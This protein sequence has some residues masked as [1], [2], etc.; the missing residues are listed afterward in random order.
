MRLIKTFVAACLFPLTLAAEVMPL[1][2][3]FDTLGKENILEQTMFISDVAWFNANQ[4]N[5]QKLLWVNEQVNRNTFKFLV[6]LAETDVD[7]FEKELLILPKNVLD[8]TEG[9]VQFEGLLETTK[10]TNF[11]Q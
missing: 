8:V 10:Q 9:R 6:E 3:E 2:V 7:D 5:S 1:K 11:F 4:K